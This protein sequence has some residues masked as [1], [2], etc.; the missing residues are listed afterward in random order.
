MVDTNVP[1]PVFTSR[2][3]V[4]PTEA[5]VLAGVQL[6]WSEAFDGNLNP[7]LNSPQG[8]ICSSEAAIVADT[9]DTFLTMV[10]LTDPAYSFG[11]Y[12]DAIGRFYDIDRLPSLPTIVQANCTGLTGVII[13][14]GALA[15]DSAGNIYQCTTAG[16]I[17]ADGPVL[18][19]FANVVNGPI[20]CASGS[21]SIY[22][23]I[24]G[25]DSCVNPDD[26]TL[27]NLEESRFAFEER[28]QASLAKN[29]RG[30]LPAVR[31]AVLDVTGVLDAYV[32][33][34]TSSSPLVVGNVTL[35]AKSLYVAAVGGTSDAVA[36]AIWSRKAPGCAYNGNTTVTVLDTNSGYSPPYPSYQV[37]FETPSGL[38]AIFEVT[39]A[40]NAQIPSNAAELIQNAIIL[41]FAGAD[42]GARAR[43]GGT[44]FAGRYYGPV[45]LLGSWAQIISIKVGSIN[46]P[47]CVFTAHI[48]PP[49]TTTMTVT[50]IASGALA[51]GQTIDAPGQIV[52]GV[53]IVSQISGSTGSTGTYL[54]SSGEAVTS[55]TFYA[56]RPSDDTIVVGIDQTPTIAAPNITVVVT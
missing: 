26:G 28:R 54:I 49:T 13:P 22:R 40:N 44:I 38:P 21:L 51:P 16:E 11:R 55:R 10:N 42:G 47:D 48:G 52:A 37:K 3:Y 31:G 2:G 45:S 27:G 29:S 5:V 19:P 36:Q 20:P 33:E 53:K 12:Q 41:A 34:N 25:W 7:A 43:I 23:A 50:A 35:V 39:L 18:L 6:D 56:V 24:P 9:N 32:T 1:K 14:I 4:A 15:Q 8:Q 46:N 17:P 30:S